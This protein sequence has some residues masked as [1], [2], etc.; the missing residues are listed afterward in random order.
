MQ[1]QPDPAEFEKLR[2]T[3]GVNVHLRGEYHADHPKKKKEMTAEDSSS[4]DYSDDPT[5]AATNAAT[6]AAGN[7]VTKSLFG[8]KKNDADAADLSWETTFK[9][10]ELKMYKEKDLAINSK[11]KLIDKK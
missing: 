9:K 1:N 11:Y 6:K 7:F 8:G 3:E 5:A 2:N 10:F 4:P